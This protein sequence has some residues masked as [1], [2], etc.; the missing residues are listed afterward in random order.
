MYLVPPSIRSG[1]TQ[2][3]INLVLSL[4]IVAS[5]VERWIIGE[6]TYWG[7]GGGHWELVNV[8][9]SKV[10]EGTDHLL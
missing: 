7:R 5:V 6:Y 10:R 3:V 1:V 2:R 9:S 8:N 4:V